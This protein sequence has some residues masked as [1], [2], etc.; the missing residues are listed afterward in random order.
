MIY[1]Q[2]MLMKAAVSNEQ[3]AEYTRRRAEWKPPATV[4]ILAEYMVPTGANKVVIIYE[5]S[6]IWDIGAMR[7][8]WLDY[9]NVDVFPAISMEE[10]IKMAPNVSRFMGVRGET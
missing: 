1:F 3:R 7:V 9:F 8:P 10:V 2:E 6:D 4:K 5:T